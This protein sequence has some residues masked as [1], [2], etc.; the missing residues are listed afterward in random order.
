MSDAE[1]SRKFAARS[2]PNVEGPMPT[3]EYR[4]RDCHHVFDRVEPL[5]EHGEKRPNCPKCKSK[6]VEQVFTPF[7]A[8]TSHKS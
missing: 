2:E 7:F 5:A 8:K 3:Y 4:C 6:D 1:A